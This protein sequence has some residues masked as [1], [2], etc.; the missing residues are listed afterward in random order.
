MSTGVI[1]IVAILFLGGVI[2]TVGDRLGTRVGKARLSLFKL[3]PR[4]TATVVTIITGSII[5]ASTLGVLLAVDKRLRDGIFEIGRIQKELNRKREQLDVTQGQ[6]E[7]TNQQKIQVEQELAQAR[8][9]QKAQQIEAQKQQAAA[10]KRLEAINQSLRAALTR[11]IKTQAQLNRT[12]G[13]L[14]QLTSQYQQAQARLNTVSQQ[15]RKLR[16][17]IQQR[18][19]ELQKLIAQRND[20]KAKIAQ[21]DQEIAKLDREIQQRDRG[22]AERNLVIAQRENRLKAL[23]KQQEYLEQEAQFLEQNLQELR[24]GNVA[25]FRGQVLAARVVRI[26][27]PSAARQAVEQLLR[28]ANRNAIQLTQPGVEQVTEQVVQP[29][30]AQVEQL[31]K[32]IDDGRDYF[33]RII[34]A[35]NY[36]VGEKSVQVF[37]D[38]ALNQLIFKAGDI[39]AK[40]NADPAA[41]TAGEVRQRVDMLLG[42]AKFSAQRA[43]ILGGTMQI[44][45]NRIQTLIRFLEQLQQYNQP[46]ELRA[47]AAQNT[48]TSGPLRIELVAVKDG[49]VVFGTTRAIQEKQ[50]VQPITRP[51]PAS[52]STPKQG[53]EEDRERSRGTGKAG[54]AGGE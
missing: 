42:A 52:S 49:Q 46:V 25:L 38:A 40:I 36:V 31:I 48:Y 19:V 30:T 17:E 1:W 35:N 26:V 20:L 6:L 8:A 27:Q 45:D 51:Q 28:E 33:V 29:S 21:R 41:M 11:Q 15:A 3:R 22:I 43:G 34:A 10:Q 13:Q 44:A 5:A 7:A 37:T 23:E 50:D 9:E 14:N 32:Q 47:I 54:K 39:L 53:I 2:A 12:R 18:Q 24:R 4:T 16:V